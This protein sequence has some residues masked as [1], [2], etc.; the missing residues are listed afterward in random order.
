MSQ[1]KGYKLCKKVKRLEV[2]AKTLTDKKLKLFM[3]ESDVTQDLVD[4]TAGRR[5]LADISKLDS[6]IEADTLGEE[7]IASRLAN[8]ESDLLYQSVAFADLVVDVFY[9]YKEAHK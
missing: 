6:A 7:A 1:V 3:S 9:K 8:A 4:M 5:L 2:S